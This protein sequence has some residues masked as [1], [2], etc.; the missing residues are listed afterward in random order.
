MCTTFWYHFGRR[1][2]P[3]KKKL[4]PH[5]TALWGVRGQPSRWPIAACRG[6]ALR[7]QFQQRSHGEILGFSGRLQFRYWKWDLMVLEWCFN[8]VFKWDLYGVFMGSTVMGYLMG[9]NG[10]LNATYSGWSMIWAETCGQLWGNLPSVTS[11]KATIIYHELWV[12]YW[13]EC[14]MG[15]QWDTEWDIYLMV[16]LVGYRMGYLTGY[17]WDLGYS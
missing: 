11:S 2:A 9:L 8:G 10:I 3:L 1:T 6:A 5:Q 16:I 17:H 4:R 7:L 15:Y 13:M 14:I 12:G